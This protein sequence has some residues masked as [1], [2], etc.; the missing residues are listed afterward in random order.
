LEKGEGQTAGTSH[1]EKEQKWRGFLRELLAAAL[2]RLS[3]DEPKE[4]CFENVETQLR[5]LSRRK[6]SSSGDWAV[7]VRDWNIVGK[8]LNKVWEKEAKKDRKWDRK[9]FDVLY[10]GLVESEKSAWVASRV[11]GTELADDIL[12]QIVRFYKGESGASKDRTVMVVRKKTGDKVVRRESF[13]SLHEVRVPEEE[14]VRTK[15]PKKVQ[16]RRKRR[17]QI[18]RTT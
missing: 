3:R 18:W 11:Q 2:R 1:G 16:K 15:R 6:G 12:G 5:Q 9:C 17:S 14:D 13:E 7:M 4:F 10:E 8:W